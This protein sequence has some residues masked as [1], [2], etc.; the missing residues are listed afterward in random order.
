MN[1]EALFWSLVG[2]SILSAAWIVIVLLLNRLQDAV[3]D[4]NRHWLN[5]TP[6]ECHKPTC[7][8]CGLVQPKSDEAPTRKGGEA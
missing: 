5:Q 1:W 7:A 2:A 6:D 8:F 3:T 4:R